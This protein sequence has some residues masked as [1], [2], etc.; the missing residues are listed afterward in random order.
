LH[1]HLTALDF[2][3]LL[4]DVMIIADEVDAQLTQTMDAFA[5]GGPKSAVA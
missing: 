5:N 4:P 2:S 3:V 1:K